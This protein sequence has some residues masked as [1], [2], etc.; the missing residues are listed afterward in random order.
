MK[1]NNKKNRGKFIKNSLIL[2]II[3]ILAAIVNIPIFNNL[4]YG[5][6]LQGGFEVLYEIHSVD[7]EE[8]TTDMVTNTYKTLSKRINEF[9]VSEPVITIEGDNKIRV[10]LAGI[11]NGEEA[12]DSFSQVANLTFRD[13]DDNLLMTSDVLDGGGASVTTDEYGNPAISLEIKDLDKFYEVTKEISSN[14]DPGKQMLVIW[15]DFEEGVDSFAN[16]YES[17]GNL[18]TSRCL[19]AASVTQAFASDVIISGGFENEDATE[20]VKLINSGSL[21]TKLEEISSKTVAA[22]F[23]EDSLEKTVTAGIVGVA[24]IMLFMIILYR[25]SGFVSSVSLMIYTTLTFAIFYVIGGT[26]TLPGIAALVIGMGMAVDATVISFARI[27]D[28]LKK[29]EKLSEAFTKGNKNA[30]TTIF[31][32]NL[33]TFIIAI[34]LFIFGESSVKGFATMLMISIFVTM[35]IMVLLNKYLLRKIVDTK[36]FD[37]KLNKFIGYKKVTKDKFAKLDFVKSRAIFYIISLIIIIIGMISLGMNGLNLGVDFKGGTSINISTNTEISEKELNK[38]F[39]ELNI[40]LEEITYASNDNIVITSSD[41]LTKDEIQVTDEYFSEKYNAKTDIGVIS[42]IVRDELIKNAFTSVL[43]A[44]IAIVMYISFRF[45]FKYAISAIVA[46]IHDALIVV[47]V[48]SLFNLEITT[49]FIAAILSIIG[50]SIN[51]TIVTFDRVR[52]NINKENITNKEELSV[53]LNKSL[54]QIFRRSIITSI[55]TIIPVL[56]LIIL[57]SYE[58]INFNIALL[59]GLLV[60]VYSS[61]FIAS[62]IWYDLNKNKIENIYKKKWYEE[63]EE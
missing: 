9:G 14:E 37:K 13:V 30:F 1:N 40:T 18:T 17:C 4:N 47:L 63:E 62:G 51:D 22:S 3:F 56:S 36:F 53:C 21:P 28:E 41:I 43:L 54:K 27:K 15:L 25:F 33:T 10:Q 57:G 38:D 31:D 8:V 58:I 45:K 50:Y 42:N 20:L 44:S 34:I 29:G 35:F 55:T 46:L 23:G 11:K 52:E 26:L 12:R 5:L 60:G 61:L 19:S 39:D 16:E 24:L 49:I 32:S 7:G 6:D 2:I 59:I 48:F